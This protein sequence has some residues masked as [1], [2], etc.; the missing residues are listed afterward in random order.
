V[1]T[2]ACNNENIATILDSD[3]SSLKSRYEKVLKISIYIL[4][5]YYL[6]LG[7][8]EETVMINLSSTYDFNGR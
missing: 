7:R 4:F 6:K 8:G 1:N 5:Y 3:L 2:N